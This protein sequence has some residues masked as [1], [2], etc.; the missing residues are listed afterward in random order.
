MHKYKLILIFLLIMTII[1]CSV[2]P[3]NGNRAKNMYISSKFPVGCEYKGLI[4]SSDGNWFTGIFTAN[5]NIIL[6][7]RNKLKNQAAANGANYIQLMG[8]HADD[9]ALFV[10]GNQN[11]VFTGQ[12]Y[13]CKNIAEVIKL[14]ARK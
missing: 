10:G 7:S 6:S 11:V 4:F 3:P 9:S 13:Y 14:N 5:L 8:T 1:A 2:T 12:A